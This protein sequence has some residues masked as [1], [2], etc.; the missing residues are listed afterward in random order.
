MDK[1]K[2]KD[3]NIGHI[4]IYNKSQL[5]RLGCDGGY[6]LVGGISVNYQD[7]IRHKILRNPIW[8]SI[9]SGHQYKYF[10][11]VKKT[12][13]N[14]HVAP[15][16]EISIMVNQMLASIATSKSSIMQ[17]FMAERWVLPGIIDMDY[18]KAVIDGEEIKI[19]NINNFG[20]IVNNYI[21]SPYNKN[22]S[23]KDMG[24]SQMLRKLLPEF[25]VNCVDPKMHRLLT[26]NIKRCSEYIFAPMNWSEDTDQNRVEES[27]YMPSQLYG[28]DIGG[29]Y[30]TDIYPDIILQTLNAHIAECGESEPDE[31]P[32]AS[33]IDHDEILIKPLDDGYYYALQQESI[34]SPFYIYGESDYALSGMITCSWIDD[35]IADIAASN[36]TDILLHSPHIMNVML[37]EKWLVWDESILP[38]ESLFNYIIKD[39]EWYSTHHEEYVDWVDSTLNW[40]NDEVLSEASR[41]LK[42]NTQEC[43]QAVAMYIAALYCPTQ[44]PS[45]DALS[46]FA[47]TVLEYE[48]K[49]SLCADTNLRKKAR[50]TIEMIK[51][52]VGMKRVVFNPEQDGVLHDVPVIIYNCRIPMGVVFTD[53]HKDNFNKAKKR[54][55]ELK[56]ML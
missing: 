4:G 32:E 46:D 6:Y 21:F 34:G 2:F 37:D 18:Y 9:V 36:V 42:L 41:A 22:S 13:K 33:S 29:C 44:F 16:E 38:P 20:G 28:F 45:H 51:R 19:S 56:K 11:K 40:A 52:A 49:A 5:R 39:P 31:T 12:G 10:C 47:R 14:I 50:N 15:V 53:H 54:L 7:K 30:V 27:E 24:R 1:K 55:H 23:K 26:E 43:A 8:D 3:V 17:A 35:V 48:Y 25:R